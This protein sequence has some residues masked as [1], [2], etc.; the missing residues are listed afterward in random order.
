MDSEKIKLLKI[1][2]KIHFPSTLLYIIRKTMNFKVSAIDL[3]LVHQIRNAEINNLSTAIIL[4]KQLLPQLGFNNELLHEF[5][6]EL[7]P[8][9][10]KGL[11]HWQYPNQ[12]SK[13]LVRLS[14][15]KIKSYLEIGA[16]NGGTFVITTEY[17]SRFHPIKKAVAVDIIDCPSLTHYK[18]TNPA[19]EFLKINSGSPAFVRYM[20]AQ[21]PFDI[22]FIDGDHSE[23]ACQRDFLTVKDKARIV[24]LHDIVSDFCP[25]VQ[26]VWQILKKEY[27]DTYDFIEFI[28]QYPSVQQ[29]LK[30]N[31]LGIGM[32]IRKDSL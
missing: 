18:K 4:E 1:L 27:K 23:Q 29:R 13:Y 16:R 11:Y 21:P 22:V 30:M 10:G 2:P 7:Y 5:P 12:F 14:T 24:V 8:Y 17:L 26:K 31:V 3:S 9:C 25:G 6:E 28:E 32:A 19:V 15:M 20:Q